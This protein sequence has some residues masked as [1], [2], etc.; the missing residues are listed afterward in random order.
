[1]SDPRFTQEWVIDSYDLKTKG[2]TGR[3]GR[4]LDW[5]LGNERLCC[6]PSALES[7]SLI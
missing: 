7:A 5:V 3:G 1:M 2:G 4:H 6:P